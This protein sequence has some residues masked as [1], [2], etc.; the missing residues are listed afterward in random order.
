MARPEPR[1]PEWLAVTP[2]SASAWAAAAPERAGQRDETVRALVFPATAPRPATAA[3]SSARPARP[4]SLLKPAGNAAAPPGS[5]LGTEPAY[6]SALARLS[7]RP[8]TAPGTAAAGRVGGATG[9]T[10]AALPSSRLD[11]LLAAQRPGSAQQPQ[12][13][14]TGA[15]LDSLL[16]RPLTAA[17]W[18]AQR[19]PLPSSRLDELLARPA[20]TAAATSRRAAQAAGAGSAAAVAIARPAAL[21]PVHEEPPPAAGLRQPPAADSARGSPGPAPSGGSSGRPGDAGAAAAAA[22]AALDPGLQDRLRERIELAKVRRQSELTG[23]APLPSPFPAQPL[24]DLL[25]CP[26]CTS[27]MLPAL[28][29]LQRRAPLAEASLPCRHPPPAGTDAPAAVAHVPPL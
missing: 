4:P 6:R 28:R 29:C 1:R 5:T 11:S 15:S 20:A 3:T 21:S 19:A 12:R 17:S 2:P 23:V 27:C 14:A 22:V 13:Q 9:T 7:Q 26:A 18:D 16:R 10:A 25:P 24:L 8:A